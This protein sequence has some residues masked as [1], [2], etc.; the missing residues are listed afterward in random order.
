MHL[1]K[2]TL[3]T[4]KNNCQVS[5]CTTCLIVHPEVRAQSTGCSPSPCCAQLAGKHASDPRGT[6]P[7]RAT[8][9]TSGQGSY[10]RLRPSPRHTPEGRGLPASPSSNPELQAPS[11][12]PQLKLAPTDLYPVESGPSGSGRILAKGPGKGRVNTSF[13]KTGRGERASCHKSSFW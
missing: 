13:W 1:N 9:N 7:G 8:E 3:D 6:R 12:Q 10:R 4:S 2:Q 5:I 11:S